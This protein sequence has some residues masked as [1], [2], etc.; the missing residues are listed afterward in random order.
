MYG[1]TLSHFTGQ[2]TLDPSELSGQLRPSDPPVPP[3]P[4]ASLNTVP[5]RHPQ[6]NNPSVYVLPPLSH[7][8]CHLVITKSTST[9]RLLLSTEAAV[10]PF[11][12]AFSSYTINSSDCDYGRRHP[13]YPLS[14]VLIIP[15]LAPVTHVPSIVIIESSVSSNVYTTHSSTC[16]R[17]PQ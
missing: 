6:Y 4:N 1:P 8:F 11:A 9:P 14:Y 13:R 10:T 7:C 17:C 5:T 15:W 3:H 12:I 2:T 16:S